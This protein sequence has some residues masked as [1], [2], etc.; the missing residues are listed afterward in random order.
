M[1]GDVLD[2]HLVA[3]NRELFDPEVGKR[4][5]KP[6]ID[7]LGQ[8]VGP[9]RGDADAV[10][11]QLLA[12][13]VGAGVVGED[14]VDVGVEAELAGLVQIVLI[15]LYLLVRRPSRAGRQQQQNSRRSEYPSSFRAMPPLPV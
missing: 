14:V 6:E 12:G 7:F 11:R 10:D 2:P 8:A 1:G 15:D 4:Q 9:F 3:V 13:V 5:V